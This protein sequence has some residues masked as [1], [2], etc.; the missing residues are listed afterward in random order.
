MGSQGSTRVSEQYDESR[1]RWY[2][3]E[4]K[5]QPPSNKLRQRARK[6]GTLTAADIVRCGLGS[7]KH[8]R[9]VPQHKS[10]LR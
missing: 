1:G 10:K 9:S 5:A 2:E 4:F 6:A 8:A 7:D 3:W